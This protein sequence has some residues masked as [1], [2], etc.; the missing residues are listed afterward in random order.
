MYMYA[1]YAYQQVGEVDACP[2]E[3]R[4]GAGEGLVGAEE[5][6]VEVR[7]HLEGLAY[8][9]GERHSDQ[10]DPELV[11]LGEVKAFFSGKNAQC[12]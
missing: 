10:H 8:D 1:G 4:H 12:I 3:G 2:D 6:L 9:E 7:D 11:F 5:D